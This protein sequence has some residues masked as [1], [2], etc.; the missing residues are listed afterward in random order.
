MSLKNYLTLILSFVIM[1]VGKAQNHIQVNIPSADAEADYIWRT[2]RDIKF[3]EANNYQVSLPGGQLME[4]LKNKARNGQLSDKDLEKLKVYMNES[5]YDQSNYTKGYKKIKEQIP[6]LNKM[7]QEV[8]T[9]G[10]KWGFKIFDTYQ[11][12]LTLYGPGGSYNPDEGSILIYTTPRGQFKN[13]DNPANT[14]IHEIVHIGIEK[15]LIQKL[16]VPHTLKER[17]VDQIAAL[18]FKKYLP[19]YRIQEM[20]ENRIDKYLKNKEAIQNLDEYIKEI[21][22]DK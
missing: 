9:M 6:L 15:S 11:I 21:M 7:L 8:K 10:W 22:K 5:I 20:G 1:C 4:N 16:N 19:D 14:I 2:I 18:C 17:I 12:N 3:F 13:Y